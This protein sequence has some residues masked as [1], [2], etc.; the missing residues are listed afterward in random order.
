MDI[1][2]QFFDNFKKEVQ[3]LDGAKIGR[4]DNINEKE[5]VANIQPLPSSENSLVLD[6]PYTYFTD[7]EGKEFDTLKAGD[8]VL[9]VYIDNDISLIMKNQD[10]VNSK[11]R[12]SAEDCI[13]IPLKNTLDLLECDCENDGGGSSVDLQH[14]Y[15]ELER[16]NI[17]KAELKHTH[18][19]DE[20]DLELINIKI[21]DLE[22]SKANESDIPNKVSQLVN[23]KGYITSDEVDFTEMNAQINR[24]DRIKADKTELPKKVSQLVNDSNYITTSDLTQIKTDID[25]LQISKA[26]AFHKHSVDDIEETKDKQFIQQADKSKIKEIDEKANKLDVNNLDNKYKNITDANKADIEDK[27]KNYLNKNGIDKEFTLGKR[28]M[29]ESNFKNDNWSFINNYTKGGWARGLL[30]IK[31]KD[32]K[33]YFQIGGKGGGQNFEYLYL[34]KAWDN[35]NIRINPNS[36]TVDI[37]GKL[38]INDKE[39]ALNEE[40]PKNVSQLNNDKNYANKTDIERIDAK[41]ASLDIPEGVDLTPVYKELEQIKAEI[42][43]IKQRMDS[44]FTWGDV[45]RK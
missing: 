25:N 37:I 41:I 8:L 14:I 15:D 6:V 13:A 9:L 35:W 45:R 30:N 10:R 4:V 39:I 29:F 42:K 23:D 12:N 19:A 2:N 28:A 33:N 18:T 43:N 21:K 40:I 24:L 1:L 3:S 16:L 7:R 34:G 26:E 11:I 31:N 17:S 36:N 5:K 20:L 38:K 32:G 22:T 27:L 44:G